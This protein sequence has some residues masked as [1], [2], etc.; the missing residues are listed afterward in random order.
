M[1]HFEIRSSKFEIFETRPDIGLT[2]R[3]FS[4]A[5]A[6]SPVGGIQSPMAREGSRSPSERRGIILAI[7]RKLLKRWF[8]EPND[9]STRLEA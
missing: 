6:A 3:R 5:D 7:L 2:A 1:K 8:P 9:R 4:L